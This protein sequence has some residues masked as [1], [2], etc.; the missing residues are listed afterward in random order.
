[1]TPKAFLDE[2]GSHRDEGA[3]RFNRQHVTDR[4]WHN[5]NKPN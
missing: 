2:R 1:M 3:R 4:G 5:K